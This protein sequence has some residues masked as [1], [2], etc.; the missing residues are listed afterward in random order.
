MSIS[1][2]NGA[3]EG[4]Y[5]QK[6]GLLYKKWDRANV[7]SSFLGAMELLLGAPKGRGLAGDVHLH[8]LSNL[9]HPVLQ[10]A[11]DHV[12]KGRLR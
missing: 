6:N 10:R 1:N 5:N 2:C 11:L 8:H 7:R 4:A 12:L 3:E 9:R